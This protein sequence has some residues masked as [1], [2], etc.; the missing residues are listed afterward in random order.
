MTW[1]TC[2]MWSTVKGTKIAVFFSKK[3]KNFEKLPIVSGPQT[4]SVIRL[5]R[6]T[7]SY[8]SFFAAPPQFNTYFENV[9]FWF[10]SSP[11]ATSCLHTNPRSRLLIFHSKV[12]LS[13]KNFPHENFWWRHIACDFRIEA[14]QTKTLATLKPEFKKFY[15]WL[16][17]F[18]TN[19][20]TM[21]FSSRGPG[22]FKDL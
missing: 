20:K 1:K 22:I 21:L 8:I 15:V 2:K 7:F 3:H 4:P 14:P 9:N 5:V 12:I 19:Q 10:K 16:F 11:L 6:D 17:F 18:S 13:Y